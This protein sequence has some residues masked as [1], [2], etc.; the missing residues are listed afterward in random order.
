MNHK[1][2]NLFWLWFEQTV[3]KKYDIYETI[4][5][6]ILIMYLKIIRINFFGNNGIWLCF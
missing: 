6:L 2:G 1:M 4:G 5:N 3:K